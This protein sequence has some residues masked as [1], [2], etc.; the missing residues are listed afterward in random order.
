MK[1][2]TRV[3]LLSALLL[4]FAVS[5][6]NLAAQTSSCFNGP[7]NTAD[8][9]VT[10]TDFTCNIYPSTSSFT[11]DLTPNLTDY[12]TVDEYPNLL[13]PGYAVVINGDPNTLSDDSSSGGLWNQSLWTAVLYW[14]ADTNGGYSSD[15][16][17]V[18][19][20][21]NTDFPSAATV[22]TY[23]E[24]LYGSG[25]DTDP[26]FFTQFGYPAVYDA[27]PNAYNVYPVPESSSMLFLGISLLVLGA[28]FTLKFKASARS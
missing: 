18:Y 11:I 7:N 2:I 25:P 1:T 22:Q 15:E 21:G 6:T 23:D 4:T 10:Y 24:N 17:T 5:Q 9:S 14:P 3:G 16:L 28:A 8:S 12:E 20:A 13:G 19:Y 26:E 27:G